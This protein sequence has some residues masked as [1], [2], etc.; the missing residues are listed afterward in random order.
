[1][2]RAA[3]GITSEQEA[4][5]ERA[6]AEA[7][8]KL[9]DIRVVR[10]SH[11]KTATVIDRLAVEALAEGRSIPAVLVLSGDGEV[12]LV[13][14]ADGALCQSLKDRFPGSWAGGSGL[15][16]AGE[17]AYWGGYPDHEE[18]VDFIRSHLG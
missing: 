9:G 10:T 1:M 12:N 5:A 18:V 17:V 14:S 8:E 16:Q 4:E 3:Q 15:G 2:D 7:E 6:L 11:S 13:G